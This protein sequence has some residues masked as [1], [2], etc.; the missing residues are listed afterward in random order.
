MIVLDTDVL[1]ALMRRQH[2]P[3]AVAWLD[4]QPS[5]SIWT[6]AV[7]VF[8]VRFGLG[9]LVPSRRRRQL[10]AAFA[11]SLV[12]DFQG[13]VLPF[14]ED[15]SREAAAR[16]AERRAAGRPVDFRD[17]EIAGI[18]AARRATLATRNTRHFEG[19][20]IKLVNPWGS[21]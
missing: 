3:I 19:L 6:T 2:D 16:A 18:V 14:D 20:G 12:E 11:R 8:E 1:S 15:A 13:R 5:E 7:T 9:Q 10:E 17:I 4:Q 21:R